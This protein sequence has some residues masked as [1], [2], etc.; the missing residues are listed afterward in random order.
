[1]PMACPV[2]LS[3]EKR[4]NLQDERERYDDLWLLFW[5]A[6]GD[7]IGMMTDT[8]KVGFF[9]LLLFDGVGMG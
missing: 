7:V 9:F 1:M 4:I 5:A 2:L 3:W 6:S 8:H